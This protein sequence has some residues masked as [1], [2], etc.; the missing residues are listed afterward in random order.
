MEAYLETIGQ[1]KQYAV[2][3]I[4]E[5]NHN[6]APCSIYMPVDKT[7]YIME[8][9]RKTARYLHPTATVSF[10]QDWDDEFSI[11]ATMTTK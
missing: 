8:V 6:S 2:A 11:K 3:L 1:Y 9:V 7:E 4:R 5:Y 10:T